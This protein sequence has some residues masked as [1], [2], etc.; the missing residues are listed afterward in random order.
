MTVKSKLGI[1]YGR[2]SVLNQAYSNNGEFREDGSLD[3]QKNRINHFISL[4]SSSETKYDIVE[5]VEDI[6][7]SA[8]DTNRPSFKRMMEQ[9][10]SRSIDFIIA[11]DLAR[12]SRSTT[13]FLNILKQCEDN[14]VEL[15]LVKDGYDSNTPH[16]KFMYTFLASLGEL[17][18]GQTSVRLKE[19]GMSRLKEYGTINGAKE[20]LGLKK[21]KN[22]KLKRQ[23]E[24]CNDGVEKLKDVLDIYLCSNSK[25][26]AIRTLEENKI[27]NSNGKAFKLT[28]LDTLLNNIKWRYR[29]KWFI[30]GQEELIE[31]PHGQVLPDETLDQVQNKIDSI[32]SRNIKC[33][34]NNHVYLISGLLSDS[35]GNK[36]HGQ[37]GNGRNDTYRYY[38]NPITKHRLDARG[39][40]DKVCQKVKLYINS[41]SKTLEKLLLSINNDSKQ[42]RK[43]LL[44]DKR[45][46]TNNR[47]RLTSL[48]N[49]SSAT[50]N[51][52]ARNIEEM[53]QKKLT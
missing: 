34:L 20:I 35:K 25:A 41:K 50:L 47:E 6:G 1:A 42:I 48:E 8:K 36:Y 16:G 32:S 37:K 19:N 39:L 23:F 49:L 15:F 14:G 38:Y 51:I 46:I 28:T 27:F 10:T 11:A 31:L 22:K 18:R 17:E 7:I 21:C 3:A 43:S 53:E 40:E 12:L 4:K 5:F 26:E 30:E 13:D 24:I 52:L 2:V 29:G 44:E 45:N 33:G 9:V